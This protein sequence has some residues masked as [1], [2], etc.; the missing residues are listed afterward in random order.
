MGSFCFISIIKGRVNGFC[1]WLVNSPYGKGYRQGAHLFC[2][3]QFLVSPSAICTVACKNNF[4]FFFLIFNL[5]FL[6][7]LYS[8][9]KITLITKV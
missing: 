5:T 3:Y 6:L 7:F 8:N 2:L 1:F 9:T 4:F